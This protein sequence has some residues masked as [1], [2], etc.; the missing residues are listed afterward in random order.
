MATHPVVHLGRSIA[1]C[2]F[3]VLAHGFL[4][5]GRDYFMRVQDCIGRD[6]GTHELRFTHCVRLDY[7]TRVRDDVWPI[8]WSDDFIDYQRWQ[9]VG[10][11]DGYVWGS[12]WSNAYPGLRA[13]EPSALAAE[14]SERLKH[15]FFE[16]T[17][18]T[19]RFFLRLIFHDIRHT[20]I[21]D[22]MSIISQVIFPIGP[23]LPHTDATPPSN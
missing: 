11:P 15:E 16:A 3:A 5:H 7:E 9:A 4:A 14:W 1:D 22:D 10:E 21:S 2:D 18:E 23:P 13:V 20:K 17:L 12:R 6:P 19:D 8:S